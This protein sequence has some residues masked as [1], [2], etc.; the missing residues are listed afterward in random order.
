MHVLRGESC[1]GFTVDTLSSE[2]ANLLTCFAFS[3]A[4]LAMQYDGFV[5]S[6]SWAMH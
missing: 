2:P 4:W 5:Y 6:T 3:L 1:P